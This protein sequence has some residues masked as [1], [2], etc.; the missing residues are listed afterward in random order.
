MIAIR[1]EI[2]AVEAGELDANDNPLKN[3]PA[4]RLELVGEWTHGLQPRAGGVPNRHADRRQS[5]GHRS[6]ASTTCSA[7]ATLICAC[8]SIEA[9]QDA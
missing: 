4:H 3:A 8:P 7:T 6:A 5:T 2:R 9:Y 1:E